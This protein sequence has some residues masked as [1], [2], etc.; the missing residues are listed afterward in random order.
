MLDRVLRPFR[1]DDASAIHQLHA[2]YATVD[3]VDELSTLDPVLDPDGVRRRLESADRA[4]V[5]VDPAGAV[6]GWGSLRTWTEDDGTH[7]CLTDGYVAPP[8]RRRGLGNRLLRESEAHAAQLAIHIG[9]SPIVL[10]GRAS[11]VQPD[12]AALLAR[13]GYRHAFTM[14]EMEHDRSPVQPRRLPD[15]IAVRAATVADARPLHALATRANAG[16]P[17]IALPSEDRLRGW[18]GRSDLAMFQVATIGERVVGFVAVSRTP[19]RI[20]VED[21]QV[22]PEHQRRGLA[23][24]MLTRAL[25]MLTQQDATPIRLQTAGHNPNGA[26]TL[27]ERLGFRVVGEYHRYRKPLVR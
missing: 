14:V 2:R 17:F 20:E 5:A 24:A 25:N 1:P 26:R 18:L 10:G 23:T 4:L 9:D 6:V 22:D 3:R 12:R 7:L 27:Y 16:R 15:G 21:V 19:G 11:A 13:N 8:A